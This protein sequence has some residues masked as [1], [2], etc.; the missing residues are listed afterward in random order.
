MK[1][2]EQEKEQFFRIFCTTKFA[3]DTQLLQFVEALIQ[4]RCA[5]SFSKGYD[6]GY[7][8]CLRGAGE[9]HT[10]AAKNVLAKQ[11]NSNSHLTQYQKRCLLTFGFVPE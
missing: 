4:E 3:R 8:D 2:N 5:K 11:I 10:T 7:T 9:T 1:L 6:R